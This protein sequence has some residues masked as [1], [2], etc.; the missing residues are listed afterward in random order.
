MRVH[1]TRWTKWLAFAAFFS[2][3]ALLLALGCAS[4]PEPESADA[5]LYVRYCSGEGCH[6]PILPQAGGR[7]YWDGQTERMYALMRKQNWPLPNEEEKKR[8]L[9]YLYKHAQGAAKN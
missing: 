1:K 9:Q 5:R 7:K 4:L 6:G 3:N 2:F 8:I